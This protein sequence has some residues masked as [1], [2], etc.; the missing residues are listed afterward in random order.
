[1]PSSGGMTELNSHRKG[2]LITQLRNDRHERDPVKQNTADA[3]NA[4]AMSNDYYILAADGA[5]HAREH[6]SR[7]QNLPLTENTI[8]LNSVLE[9]HGCSGGTGVDS[10]AFGQTD[11][12]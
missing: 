7:Q 10:G 4:G 3:A 8:N 5:V 9:K 11:M 2:V 1:M 12:S 6:Q